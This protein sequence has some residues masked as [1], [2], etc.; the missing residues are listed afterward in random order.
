MWSIDR[1]LMW[2]K[3]KEVEIYGD[4]GGRAI[5]GFSI[6]TQTLQPGEI[7]IALQ[8]TRQDGHDFV[9]DA[10][11]KG[12]AG[13]MVSRSWFTL[14]QNKRQK[15]IFNSN[16]MIVVPDPLVG[17]QSLAKWHR[18]TF[19]CPIIGITG[20]NGKT[21]TKEMLAKILGMRGPVLKTEGNLN[22]HIG[23]PLT[24][25]RLKKEDQAAVLEMGISRPGDM[26]LLCDIAKP[27]MGI[28]TNIG[29]AH[30]EFLG[31]IEGVAT[32]KTVLFEAMR[33]GGT[34]IINQDDPYLSP[35]EGVCSEKWTYSIGNDAD[36]IATEIV[37]NRNG[38]AFTLALNRNQKGGGGKMKVVL[39]LLGEHHVYNALAASAGA[40]ALGYE[41][42]EIRSALQDI[43]PMP[44]RGEIIE[45]NGA[46][47][48]L[49][50]YNANPAS[51][52]AALLTLAGVAPLG[53]HRKVAILGDMLELG[54]AAKSA[55]K[56][57]GR[58]VAQNRI[59]RLIAV[60]QFCEIVACGA[61]GKGMQ[62]QAITTFKNLES[63]DLA[64]EIQS[65]DVVLIKGS[66]GMGMER[67]LN[68]SQREK[69][70]A[71]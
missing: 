17:L 69:V 6:S 11:Y 41:F 62:K 40:L 45:W 9:E 53:G 70:T 55:H 63:L 24:L 54:S 20:S 3:D 34:A 15:N 4:L 29:A 32:E 19:Q 68:V 46:T 22:N 8:G 50:A 25:L 61:L 56:E 28:I 64:H 12:A 1:L 44:L 57:L 10:L 39:S 7:F 36:L 18:G 58:K 59:D 23:V 35:W 51:M 37:S 21:T 43:S 52:Q 67:L 71:H 33:I 60:G 13:A 16:F 27:T 47:I 31:N 48:L 66:R 30:L 2:G 49:D 42:D 5:S 38:L 65:G 26:S 14:Q